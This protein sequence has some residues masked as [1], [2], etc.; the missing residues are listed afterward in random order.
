VNA[1]AILS[2]TPDIGLTHLFHSRWQSIVRACTI[3]RLV[4]L[5]CTRGVNK[6]LYHCRHSAVNGQ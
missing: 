6:S 3:V 2:Q 4:T 1:K 5:E